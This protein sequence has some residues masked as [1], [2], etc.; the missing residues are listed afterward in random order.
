[1]KSHNPSRKFRKLSILGGLCAA[2]MVVTAAGETLAQEAAPAAGGEDKSNVRY[3]RK[4]GKVRT[5]DTLDTKFKEEKEQQEKESKRKV[6][7]M[8][9][10]SFAKKREAVKQEIADTQIEQLKRLLKA[11]DTSHSD[12]P[13]LL[14][15]LCDHFLEK[16]AYFENQVGALYEEVY[17]A[18]EKGNKAKVDQ[19]KAKQAKFEGQAKEA[20]EQAVKLYKVLV[21]A[22]QLAKYKR[23]DEA[24]YF[25]AFELGQLKREAEM[26]EAYIR[27]IQDFPNSQYIPN[28][29]LSFADYYFGQSKIGDAL[30]LYEKVITFKDS[31]V[32]AYALYKM[33]WCHLNPVGSADPRYDLSLDFFV[34]TI[35]A[36]LEGRAGSEGN[37]KQLRRDARRDLV[38]AFAQAGKPTKAW[39]FF[40][41]IGDGPKED[42]NMSR[43]MM[44]LLAV[45]YFGQGMYT[46]STFVYEKLQELYPSD[47]QACE[48][49]GRIVINALATDNKSVQWTETAQL[50]EYW[51]KFK[52]GDF[53]Q[54]VKRK[55]R[56][57]TLDT[58][59]QMATV[60][61]DEAEKTKNEAT[62]ALA[63]QAYEGFLNTFPKDK[64][65]YEIQMY[66]SE[67]LWARAAHLINDKK[68]KAEGLNKFRK[69]HDEFIKVLELN[70]E[71]KFTT[72]A[73]YAQML[74]MKNAL[75]YDETGGQAKSC[76][77][78][79][80]GVCVYQDKEKKK[81]VKTNEKTVTDTAVAYPETDYL[82]NEKKMLEA[83]DTYQKYVKD[84]KDPELPKIVYH[85]AKL[86][87]MHNKFKEARPLLE[88][89]VVKFD[90]TVYAAWC[91]EMLLDV[92]TI[93]WTSK[94]N[95]PEE[96]LKASDDLE[97]WALKMQKMKVYTHPEAD[98]LKKAIPTLLAGI[99]WKKAMNYRDLGAAGDPNGFRMC[100]EQFL[101]VYNEYGDEH[102]KASTLVY[103]A[104][105]C[106]EAAYLLGQ[107]VRWRKFLLEK[108]PESPHFQTTL[109]NLAGNYQAIAM[110]D[111][112]AERMEVYAEKYAKDKEKAPD[113]LRN[114]Y[115]FRL[116]LGQSDQANADLIKYEG[117]Y[118]KEN[119]ELAAK[120][121]WSKSDILKTDEEKLKH[122]Q[123]YLGTY[124]KTGGL[125]RRIV[126]EAK[127]GQILW[128]QSCEKGLL[129]D[130][131]M[132]IKRKVAQAGQKARDRAAEL[133]R[134]EKKIK[135]NAAKSGGKPKQE[136]PKN[137]GTA[138]SGII[139]VYPRNKK[140]SDEAQK[141]F[142][143]VI[144]AAKN[145]IS[146]PED[147]RQRVE[148]FRNAVAMAQ[149][150]KADVQYEEYVV[151]EMP[152][153]LSF[154]V[155]EWKKDI[156]EKKLENEYK[157]QVKKRDDSIKRFSEFYQK[158]GKI[159][160]ELQKQYDSI[161]EA[162][163]SPYWMLAAAARSAMVSQNYADQLYRAEVPAEFKTEEEAYAFCD[164]LSDK[165][166]PHQEAAVAKFSYC[167][168][169]STT[170]QFFNDFSRL[171]EEELQQRDA[172][173]YPSTS[174]IF[175]KSQ[176][177]ASRPDRVEVQTDLEGEKRKA[178]AGKSSSLKPKETPA[179]AKT[180]KT[181]KT[182][183]DEAAE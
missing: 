38:Q 40:Q 66:Y 174:E 92:L 2:A 48:W 168:E 135:A 90:G 24:L 50:G 63:E 172:D 80:E 7:M 82:E 36:T 144:K 30:Q 55:C 160:S 72:D 146:I 51:T 131:C 67:L 5:K 35:T 164:E 46:E 8:Q 142:D 91:S 126:A 113:F 54:A 171:C 44:E 32:Y 10:A 64:D 149:V 100:A 155:E 136:I 28:A 104:G 97:T 81:K 88:E 22:P 75:E 107:S 101:S 26:K 59:K 39:E 151:I 127:I 139:T 110:Y 76:K 115:L 140:R 141:Y 65:A 95:T 56:D 175:G 119:P 71:G 83:Y 6:D 159:G 116:G 60:W 183:D 105:E 128:R 148:D 57:E 89:M 153:N 34:K 120:I 1:M 112:A 163:Q 96:A 108:F 79:S 145:K 129:Y 58:M 177:T 41:K 180:E 111:K 165:A 134:K 12:Y 99:G 154:F 158:K 62:Y 29:Y 157:E 4:S 17:L 121:F 138:T 143:G 152:G 167:L 73:A 132:T 19:L 61:H 20:S 125:D 93:G 52:D 25:Y 18:E 182:D 87:M 161:V 15:R 117:L 122:A 68:T 98:E 133:K 86:M 169:K 3:S 31:P 103:N 74:A 170:F 162:K 176:Y 11:T 94:G 147:D 173:K 16:K 14:F 137:C 77:T 123:E 156:G 102:E 181:E 47:P 179:E 21:T 85:R 166:L 42:E 106:Y 45:R 53:K 78:D 178:D 49:Q 114:A 37:A 84:A 118:K 70:P 23:L 43:K 9:G 27:L 33:A 13:D 124:G 130:S 69:A 109:S 150:Y